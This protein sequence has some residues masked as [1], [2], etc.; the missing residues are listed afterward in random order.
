MTKACKMPSDPRF[1]NLVGKQFG[2]LTVD[3][4]AGQRSGRIAHWNCTCSC[5]KQSVVQGSKL[6]GGVTQSCGCLMVMRHFKHGHASNGSPSPE[7]SVWIGIKFR[8]LNANCAAYHLYG[9][10]GVSMCGRWINSFAN[11]LADMGP[12]PSRK[13]SIDRFPNNNGNYEPG[14]CRWA[15]ASQQQRNRRDS[16]LVTCNGRTLQ[17]ADWADILGVPFHA[18]ID[19]LKR[20]APEDAFAMPYKP[21]SR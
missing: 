2:R 4:F 16:R 11:F 17:I 14:N 13:H 5:G 15:T 12:R 10:R 7:Y 18:L 19:R 1:K 8:C 20:H 3:S 6:S 21:R 9:G